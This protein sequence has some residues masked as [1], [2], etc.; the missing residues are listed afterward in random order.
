MDYLYKH[1][2]ALTECLVELGL[3]AMAVGAAEGLARFDPGGG[4]APQ[5]A[6]SFVAQCIP[7]AG[8]DQT[9]PEADRVTVSRTYG[10][11]AMVLLEKAVGQGFRDVTRLRETEPFGVL[12]DREDF[13][14]LIER[15]SDPEKSGG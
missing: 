1:H 5:L 10:D 8:N 2:W 9:L 11:K 13:Q 14:A 4:A 7:L 12:Q 3:H 15:L 6:A